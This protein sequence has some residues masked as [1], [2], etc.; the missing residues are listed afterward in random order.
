MP[1]HVGRTYIPRRTRLKP[2]DFDKFDYTEDCRGCEFLQ[3]GIG[4]RQNHSD[5]CRAR[6][7]TELDKS[8]EGR[9]RLGKSKDRIDH[10]VEKS[11]N[12][13]IDKDDDILIKIP[14]VPLHPDGDQAMGHR[15]GEEVNIDEGITSETLGARLGAGEHSEEASGVATHGSPIEGGELLR[16]I[17]IDM[18]EESI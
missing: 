10:W 2:D 3:T 5:A 6:I 4:G 1:E 7:E 15:A 17:D 18:K 12:V 14:S 16:D 11:E 8:E 13:N 9:E